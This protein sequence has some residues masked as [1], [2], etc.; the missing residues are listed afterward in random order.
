MAD[1]LK[2][3]AFK[4]NRND[5]N[6][7]VSRH[8][9]GLNISNHE[10]ILIIGPSGSG[11]S[12]VLKI[13]SGLIYSENSQIF[14]KNEQ[15]LDFLKFRKNNLSYL[16]QDLNFV[17]E[18]T[19]REN[20]LLDSVNIT[21]NQFISACRNFKFDKKIS[22]DSNANPFSVGEKQKIALV[23]QFLKPHDILFL[24]EPTS[25]LDS[26]SAECVFKNIHE[27][28]KAC[29]VASHDH[30]WTH[31]FDRTIHIEDLYK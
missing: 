3:S 27:H 15:I 10:K 4:T 26:E 30:R 18:L 22:F 16:S 6:T 17:S 7:D 28:L 8:F 25:N 29:L 20:F 31:L 12:T 1:L 14:L 9:H 11:K 5:I 2:A 24:D 23:R 13:L 19:L 21:E